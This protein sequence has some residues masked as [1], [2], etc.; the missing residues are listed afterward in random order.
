[1]K[2]WLTFLLLLP[3][4]SAQ[5]WRYYAGDPGGTK[6]SRL[7]QI[8]KENVTRLKAA[9]TYHIGDVSDGKKYFSRSA[10]ESTPLVVDGAMY[11]TSA[12]SRLAALDPETGKQL[13]I[14]DPRLDM[15]RNYNLLINRGASYWT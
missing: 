9:W 10:F 14:F 11:V 5:E 13:W 1:M 7:D 6:Y 15:D 12:F 2:R 4:L 3:I 8:N